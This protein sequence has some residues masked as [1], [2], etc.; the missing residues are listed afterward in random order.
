MCRSDE[1]AWKRGIPAG[2][3]NSLER[4]LADTERALFFALVEIHAGAVIDDNYDSQGMKPS[5]L[6]RSTP[7]TQQ[8]KAGLVDEWT[9]F[10]LEHRAQ[11]QAWLKS[12]QT[13]PY[14]VDNSLD[15]PTTGA[16]GPLDTT[17]PSPS[18]AT[19]GSK[20]PTTRSARE[21][22]RH[23]GP[24]GDTG[25]PGIQEDSLRNIRPRSDGD[26]THSHNPAGVFDDG[27]TIDPIPDVF[28]ASRANNFAQANKMVYF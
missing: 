15:Q 20:R 2:Y 17:T 6:S 11:A 21:S 26:G 10:P 1:P 18:V 16:E 27:R 14:A 22:L 13:G 12:R 5:V 28:E 3:V 4:R 9:R 7:T 23:L 8:E 24:G 25:Q 19:R